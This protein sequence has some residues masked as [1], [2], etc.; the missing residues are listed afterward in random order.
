LE[1]SE[2]TRD[3]VRSFPQALPLYEDKCSYPDGIVR[4]SY[5]GERR[6]T[7]GEQA[8]LSGRDFSN[9]DSCKAANRLKDTFARAASISPARA[10]TSHLLDLFS[11]GVRVETNT[12]V[13]YCSDGLILS[14][15][16][17]L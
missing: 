13:F 6:Q 1:D 7:F 17:G 4:F 11:H 15:K 2:K 10:V 5:V 14:P 8:F 3:H 12:L 16:V 9:I